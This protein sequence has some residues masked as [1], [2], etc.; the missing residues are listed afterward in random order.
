MYF[1]FFLDLLGQVQ[2]DVSMINSNTGP[3]VELEKIASDAGFVISENEGSGNCLFYA[4]SE[5]L[6]LVKGIK[7]SHGE[8]R[9]SI[10]QYL[11]NN[12]GLVR[13]V[14]HVVVLVNNILTYIY[15]HPPIHAY[16]LTCIHILYFLLNVLVAKIS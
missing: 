5:Q 16:I 13:L 8:L 12:P 3:S 14:C 4:L 15:I 9:Q 10:V 11:L 1:F 7:I 2:R 6:S